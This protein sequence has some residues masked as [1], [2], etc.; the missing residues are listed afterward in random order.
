MKKCTKCQMELSIDNFYGAKRKD[1]ENVY[2]S[3]VCKS[4]TNLATRTRRKKAG[5]V[6]RQREA[7]R[8]RT[9]YHKKREH[10]ATK[11]REKH[12]WLT[13]GLTM[14]DY[15]N[16]LDFQD[17]SCAI[18]FAHFVDGKANV[19]HCHSTGRVRGLLCHNCNTSI[20]LMKESIENLKSAISYLTE[21]KENYTLRS[22][23]TAGGTL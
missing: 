23:H 4:C 6:Y 14:K 18:C 19:D 17:W 1:K 9:A 12:L 11:N 3:S 22:A 21:A 8:K 16:L 15:E 5:D 13:Y 2:Y 20:G 7:E 10:F